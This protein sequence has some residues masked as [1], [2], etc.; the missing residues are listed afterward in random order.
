MLQ[1]FENRSGLSDRA[2]QRTPSM[3]PKA[4]KAWKDGMKAYW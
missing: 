2:S 4:T 1:I 3:D